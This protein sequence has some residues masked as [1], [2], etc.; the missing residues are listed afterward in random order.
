MSSGKDFHVRK[1]A[2]GLNMARLLA[3]RLKIFHFSRVESLLSRPFKCFS[4]CV[5]SEEILIVKLAGLGLSEGN[6]RTHADIVS[7]ASIDED[8]DLGEQSWN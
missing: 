6:I 5:I 1:V 7:V 3:I 2:T 4:P 8:G